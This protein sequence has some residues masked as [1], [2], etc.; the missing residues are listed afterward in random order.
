MHHISERLEAEMSGVQNGKMT[1]ELCRQIVARPLL[2]DK[3]ARTRKHIITAY[4]S[5]LQLEI[6]TPGTQKIG[7]H[8]HVGLYISYIPPHQYSDDT[9]TH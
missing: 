8:M 9:E 7:E 2:H 1:D 6:C 4:N 3:D 5:R